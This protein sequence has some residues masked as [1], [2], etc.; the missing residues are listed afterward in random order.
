[1]TQRDWHDTAV[2]RQNSA[3]ILRAEITEA[4]ISVAEHAA[5][6]ASQTAGAVMT[7]AGV[8]ANHGHGRQVLESSYTG[9][10]SAPGVLRQLAADVT[11]AHPDL[12]ALAISQRLGRLQI[13]DVALA[14]AISATDHAAALAACT[15]L[16]HQLEHQLP[17]WKHELFVDGTAEWVT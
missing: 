12:L 8:I 9:H 7:F 10:P 3:R 16:I 4:E 15:A 2:L 11:S 14:C 17:V 5:L 13:G 6:V 1:M